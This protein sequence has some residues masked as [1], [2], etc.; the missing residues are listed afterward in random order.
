MSGGMP[1]LCR[2]RAA[3]N[4]LLL[5]LLTLH[6]CAGRRPP[7]PELYG[8]LAD[9]VV[10]AAVAGADGTLAHVDRPLLLDTLS[11]GRLGSA[12][13]ET[14]WSADELRRQVRLDFVPVAATDVL[15]CPDRRPCRLRA[16]GSYVEVWSAEAV[17]GGL[18]VTV[19]LV[20]NRQDLFVM[21]TSTTHR[22]V[23][24]RDPAGWRLAERERLPA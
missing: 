7:L 15:L 2:G 13:G 14:A 17:A 9:V 4:L 23:L 1:I 11:F 18:E 19:T 3:W 5:L 24:R 6:G 21:T 22:L 10:G 12:L 20:Q 16:G 8:P